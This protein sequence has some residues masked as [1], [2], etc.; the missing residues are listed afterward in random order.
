M[1]GS[2]SVTFHPF[3]RQVLS[4][5]RKVTCPDRVA[6]PANK[7]CCSSLKLWDD[8]HLPQCLAYSVG[9]GEAEFMSLCLY[10]LYTLVLTGPF[11]LGPLIYFY[12]F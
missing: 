12:Y 1:L 2:S 8:R 5:N 3:L 11:S 10:S 6:I 7:L 4:L 9:A